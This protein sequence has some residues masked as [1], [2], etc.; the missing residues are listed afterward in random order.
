M[1][2][3][4]AREA[5]AVNTDETDIAD[6]GLHCDE[7]NSDE[8]YRIFRRGYFQEKIY[9]ML[10]FYPWR[11]KRCGLR[12]MMRERGTGEQA[13]LHGTNRIWRKLRSV[14]SFWPGRARW[15]GVLPGGA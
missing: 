1:S 3:E 7:C 10:G 14:R 12:L 6:A 11:C 5:P 8:V 2:L 15:R 4:M 13:E 9:P